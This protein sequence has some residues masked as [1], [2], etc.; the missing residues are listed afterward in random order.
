MGMYKYEKEAFA[1][2]YKERSKEYKQRITSWRNAPTVSKI[3]KPSNIARARE[4]GYKAK[5]GIIVARVKVR[6]GK[7]KRKSFDGGRKPSKSGRFFTRAKSLQSI[8]EDRAA[9]KFPNCE[10]LNSYFVGKSG[11]ESF[12]EIILLER[13]NPVIAKNKEYNRIISQKGRSF[14][15]LTSSGKKHRGIK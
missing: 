1:K 9:K 7:K 6:G 5:Q 4:L 11:V 10:V 14:R 15:G 13:D 3:N 2:E 12:Y 8:A